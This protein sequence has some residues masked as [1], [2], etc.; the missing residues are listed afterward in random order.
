MKNEDVHFPHCPMK[1][2][3]ALKKVKQYFKQQKAIIFHNREEK[4]THTHMTKI[5][6]VLKGGNRSSL[7]LISSAEDAAIL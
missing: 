2:K 7:P 3:L 5:V 4:K 6:T 1:L